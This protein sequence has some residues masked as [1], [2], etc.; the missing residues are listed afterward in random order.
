MSLPSAGPAPPPCPPSAGSGGPRAGVSGSR[1]QLALLLVHIALRNLLA[2]RLKTLIVGGIILFGVVLVVVG[3]SLLDSIDLGMRRSIVGSLAG[4][5]QVYSARSKEELA[6]YGGMLGD[7]D[8]APIQD[9]ARLKRTLLGVDNVRQVVPMGI[10][11][12]FASSGTVLDRALEKL[13]GSCRARLAGDGSPELAARLAAEKAHVRRIIALMREA[14]AEAA[15]LLV[16]AALDQQLRDD[17]ERAASEGFWAA[18]DAD[19]LGALEFLENRVAPQMPEGGMLYIRYVGTDPAAFQQ[20]F[21]RLEIVGGT[22]IPARRRGI[23]LGKLYHEEMC[24][25]KTARR[26]DRMREKMQV[27]GKRIASDEQLQ[28]WVKE[29]QSQ[30]REITLQLDPLKAA[31]AT[32]RLRAAL[33][34][35]EGDLTVLM[36]RLLATDD[37]NFERHYAIFYEQLAPL[38]ELYSVKVGDELTIKAFTRAGYL[39]A[40][41]VHVYGIY[42][43]QGLEKSTFAGLLALMDLVSF[44]EL[45]GHVTAEQA[46][47]IRRLKEKAGARFVPREQAE[48]ALFGEGAAPVVDEAAPAEPTAV[49]DELQPAGGADG[50]AAD[51]GR[52]RAERSYTQAE[53]ESGVALNAAVILDD[54]RRLRQT[55]AAIAQAL[56]ADGLPM[57]VV[58]WQKASGMVGQFITLSRLI[59]Y[60]AV[61]ILFVIALVIVNNAMVMATLQ[62]VKEIGTLRAI[63]AQ[64]ELVLA[65]L[66]VEAVVVGLLF[67]GAGAALGA[68][69]VELVGHVGIPASSDVLY[70]FF[71]GPRLHPT[72]GGTSMA[73]ALAIVLVVSILSGLYPALLAMRITPLEAMQSGEE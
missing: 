58:D 31:Q 73:I 16:E 56:E 55:M 70:F 49:I 53:L 38:I 22:T 72:V 35:E 45:Y 71:S 47:E 9:F 4:H 20:A 65:M 21:D 25:L 46:E 14:L 30:V 54:E 41:N 51:A 68:G 64:R 1:L 17:L 62:R 19:T 33:G 26:L 37:D 24:K 18:F 36:T 67:G 5:L 66:L 34:G 11:E 15:K 2:S 63:G 57:R 28:R 23:L 50:G 60:T 12:A 61:L 42:Q 29:N 39:K 59:L 43:F 27:N 3:S 44:R 13:R 7:P 8:L 69:I 6:L 10:A 48:Q 40:V 52:V 32:E